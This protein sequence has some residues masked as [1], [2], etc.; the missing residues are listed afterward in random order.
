MTTPA[1]PPGVSDD[2]ASGY[3][4]NFCREIL[5]GQEPSKW[6]ADRRNPDGPHGRKPY[7]EIAE[8]LNAL[9]AKRAKGKPADRVS[10][11]AIRRWDPTGAFVARP[12]AAARGEPT[13]DEGEAA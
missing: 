13:G 8:E 10:Y 6:I 3:K 12:R 2:E 11:E 4:Y 7:A 5:R 1:P 9:I